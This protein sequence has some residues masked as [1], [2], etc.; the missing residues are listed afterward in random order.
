MLFRFIDG[1]SAAQI[2]AAG[3]ALRAMHGTIPEVRS[4]TFGP[5]LANT[6]GEWSHV[7]IVEV[8]DMEAVA[9]YSAHAVH[10]DVVL[11]FIAPI[12]EARLAVDVEA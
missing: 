4:V 1:A 12:R 6:T 3:D 11:R 9:A 5:N 2:A 10:L 8:D 7:L